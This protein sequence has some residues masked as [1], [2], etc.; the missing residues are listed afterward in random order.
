MAAASKEA[1]EEKN[2]PAIVGSAGLPAGIDSGML[3]EAAELAGQGT[4]RSIADNV[5]PFVSLLQDMSPEVKKRD[6]QYIEGAE[7]GFML[8]KATR[9][10]WGPEDVLEFIPCAFQRSVNQWT[11]RESGGGFKGRHPLRGTPEDTMKA[12][13]GKQ[14]PDPKDPNK[15]VWK[16]PNGDDLID[17]RYHFG[18]IAMP[19]GSLQPAVMSFSSTGHQASRQWMTL[20]NNAQLPGPNG[21]VTAPSW[22]KKYRIRAIPRKNN[23]GEF[24]VI[25]V[26]DLGT[27]GWIKDAG[28]RSRCKEIH[29]SVMA[30]NLQAAEESAGDR[31]GSDDQPP[32]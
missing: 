11:P 8:N 6:P 7:P 24:F 19:D 5:V 10:L 20:M 32:I 21:P 13:G 9:Q 28:V 16:M 30:G 23:K 25:Q 15:T 12:L 27:D 26:D 18:A 31:S 4:S 3:A 29:D 17:T 14:H 2:V 1:K 22:F